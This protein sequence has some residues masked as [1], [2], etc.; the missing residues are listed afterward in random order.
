M[1]EDYTLK[2]VGVNSSS[3]Y[4]TAYVDTNI[5]QN[6]NALYNPALSPDLAGINS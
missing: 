4:V 2:I 3:N 6:N 5:S 1:S